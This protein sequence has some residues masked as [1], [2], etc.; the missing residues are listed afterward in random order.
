M[1]GWGNGEWWVVELVNNL[2]E[3]GEDGWY[4]GLG[5]GNWDGK[6]IT[7]EM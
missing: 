1:S 5:M 7:F 4:G 2:I 6:G 3:E